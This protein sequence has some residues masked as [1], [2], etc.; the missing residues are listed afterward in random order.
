MAE[1]PIFFDSDTPG[2]PKPGQRTVQVAPGAT[3][4]IQPATAGSWRI[5]G[6]RL[7]T[8]ALGV[9]IFF[10][11]GMFA[12]YH[13][14]LGDANGPQEKFH[15]GDT[16]AE[17]KI[18]VIEMSATIMPPYTERIIKQ[19]KKA[20]KDKDVKGV[21][22]VIDSPGGL[23][24]DSHQIYHE[25]KKVSAEK[26]MFVQMKRLAASGGYYIAMGA[27]PQAKLYAEPTT[28]TG[29][30]GVIM[31]RYD[32]TQLAEK[33]GVKSEPLTT[34]EFKDSLSPFK[35]LSERERELW[36]DIIH[37]SFEQFTSVIDENR[38]ALDAD[39]VKELATGQIFTAKDAK[40]KGLID[41]IGFEED[42]LEALKA[43]LG[44]KKVR[45]VKYH[46]PPALVDVLMGDARTRNANPW[47]TFLEAS[48][49]RAYYYCSWLP[50]FPE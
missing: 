48:V 24:A 33:V 34:G 5:W 37:Q 43:Q 16:T 20:A 32:V 23:V 19:I 38:E 45:V 26:P 31:P 30:I 8:M 47:Q 18:A 17:Q 29:S 42:A 10:N 50:P 2:A 28:W 13:E 41:E 7:L 14:Y 27:G 12:L 1:S 15:S 35:P 36:S 46:A 3:V 22:L 21:L 6:M 39:K 40:A 9:S 11:L 49:P 25:L 4:I 44:L